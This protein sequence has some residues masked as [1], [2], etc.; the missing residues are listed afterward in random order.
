[1]PGR[2]KLFVAIVLAIAAM[3]MSS[4]NA[5]RI[6]VINSEISALKS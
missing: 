2:L 6:M 4:F 3:A 5:Y 1:M